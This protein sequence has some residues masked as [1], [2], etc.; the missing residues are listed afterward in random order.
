ANAGRN[1]G[2]AYVVSG[3]SLSGTT[4]RIESISPA[5]GRADVSTP[6]RV[7]GEGF[8]TE[9]DMTVTAGGQSLADFNV[10]SGQVL[11][12]ALPPSP[13][14]R[15]IDFTL[16]TRYGEVTFP[17]GFTYL[18]PFVRG[19]ADLDGRVTL[20][21]PLA[22]LVYLFSGAPLDCLDAGDVNDDGEL[23]L[24]DVLHALNYLFTGG[25]PPRPPHPAAGVDPTPDDLACG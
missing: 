9:A 22:I 4:L 2:E 8:T 14:G 20:T 1:V 12:L 3:Y 7:L 11:E 25:P 13:P 10:V 17:A 6:V 21:D 19:D 18:P 23:N 5:E 16:R 24:S 15:S